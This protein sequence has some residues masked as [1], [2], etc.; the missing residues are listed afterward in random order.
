MMI[1]ERYNQ[2]FVLPCS[3]AGISEHEPSLESHF[4][5]YFED[6]TRAYFV[7][8]AVVE[9]LCN[10]VEHG[11][12][13]DP[14]QDAVVKINVDPKE[15]ALCVKLVDT[16]KAIPTETITHLTS[17]KQAMPP[18]SKTAGELPLSG[19]GLNIVTNTASKIE[20]KRI[21]DQNEITLKFDL[22]SPGQKIT[23]DQLR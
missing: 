18:V 23:D 5:E 11:F 3:L 22:F 1:S 12:D 15:S 7:T 20:Y 14:P 9:L 6:S 13:N 21:N 4:A 10:I 8:L 2:Q 16:A 17:R 19:W